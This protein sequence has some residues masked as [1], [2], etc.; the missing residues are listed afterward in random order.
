M[1]HAMKKPA[2]ANACIPSPERPDENDTDSFQRVSV[3]AAFIKVPPGNQQA[4]FLAYGRFLV[5]TDRAF[6]S[7]IS[8]QWHRA[9]VV[10]DHSNGWYAMESH[11]LSF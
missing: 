9:A 8:R 10:P 3:V 5:P 1:G 6:P 7:T 11:H 4:G 2:A